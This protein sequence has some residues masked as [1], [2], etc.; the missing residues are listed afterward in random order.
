MC[1]RFAMDILSL[2][3]PFSP[4]SFMWTLGLTQISTFTQPLSS[5]PMYQSLIVI[6]NS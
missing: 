5:E 6:L 1:V 4:V 3:S 2:W